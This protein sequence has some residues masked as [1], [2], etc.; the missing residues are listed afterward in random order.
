MEYRDS[1]HSNTY[2]IMSKITEIIENNVFC[3][4][5]EEGDYDE[6]ANA[7][8]EYAEYYA[9][10]CLKEADRLF[11]WEHDMEYWEGDELPSSIKLPEHE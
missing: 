2:T 9:A 6:V 4:S 8:R 5:E 3:V 1:Q 10:K 7:M 11:E